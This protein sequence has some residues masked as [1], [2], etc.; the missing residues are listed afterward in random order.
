[1]SASAC[2]PSRSRLA[3]DIPST[4][5][6]KS[7]CLGL[8]NQHPATK[9]TAGTIKLDSEELLIL[10]FNYLSHWYLGVKLDQ[11]WKPCHYQFSHL[12]LNSHGVCA[13][14]TERK[15]RN[16]KVQVIISMTKILKKNLLHRGSALKDEPSDLRNF[17]FQASCITCYSTLQSGKFTP[18]GT[19]CWHYLLHG[20]S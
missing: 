15:T 6:H 19:K 18:Y 5:V 13:H 7:G 12:L 1:M 20:C 4:H 9:E 3:L 16:V 14:L 17:T 10:I 2:F 11:L 8:P